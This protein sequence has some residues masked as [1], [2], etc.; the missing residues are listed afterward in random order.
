MSVTETDDRFVLVDIETT[1]LS[2]ITDLILEV[3]MVITD[4]NLEVIDIFDVQIWDSP[5][6]DTTWSM[7]PAFISNMHTKSG[8][9]DRCRAEGLL[10][11]DAEEQACEFLAGHGALELPMTGSSI[12]FDRSFLNED[13]PR[14][15]EM[16][17]HRNIDVSSIKELCRRFNPELYAKLDTATEKKGAH[18]A[19]DDCMDTIGELKFYR[20]NFMFWTAG[21]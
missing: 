14:L 19:V 11:K 3:G 9:L 10:P 7:V 18:R 21:Q 1:G 12:H 15:N 16:F 8:L 17:G 6:Y 20:D 13:M 5:I 2:H 4:A